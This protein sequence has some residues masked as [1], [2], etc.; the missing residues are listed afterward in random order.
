MTR[1]R[2]TV[3]LSIR[4]TWAAHSTFARDRLEG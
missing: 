1:G 4:E 3:D 2:V